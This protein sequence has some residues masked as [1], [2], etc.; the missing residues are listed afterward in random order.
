MTRELF[1]EELNFIR[2]HLGRDM[3]V[4]ELAKFLQ[5]P[6][7]MVYEAAYGLKLVNIERRP[8]T[9]YTPYPTR[10]AVYVRKAKAEDSYEPMAHAEFQRRFRPLGWPL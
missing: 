5:A 6:A 9:F 4:R 3:M 1:P 7:A 8:I 2:L 10:V